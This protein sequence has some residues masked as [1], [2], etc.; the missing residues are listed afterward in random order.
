MPDVRFVVLQFC[1]GRRDVLWDAL[2]LQIGTVHHIRLASAFGWTHRIIATV[3]IKPAVLRPCRTT[4]V[5]CD[6]FI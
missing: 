1:G 5:Q 3:L 2:Q 4:F 6:G